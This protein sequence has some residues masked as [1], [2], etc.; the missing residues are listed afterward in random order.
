MIFPILLAS[1]PPPPDGSDSA[2]LDGEVGRELLQRELEKPQYRERTSFLEALLN[3]LFDLLSGANLNPNLPSINWVIVAFLVALL[4]IVITLI[5]T[6]ESWRV[7]SLP[8]K[9]KRADSVVFED[10]R[11]AVQYLAAAKAAVSRE[12]FATA[13][14]E[15]FRHMLKNC[16]GE[17]VLTVN[18]GL[19]A[20]EAS[21]KL[22]RVA[23]E[24][25]A[26]LTWAADQFNAFRFGHHEARPEDYERLRSVNDTLDRQI[27]SHSPQAH[28]AANTVPATP[29]ADSDATPAGSA[30]AAAAP[31]E[32]AP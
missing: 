24:M 6:N 30:A 26:E 29:L 11:T 32:V 4:V 16:E 17:G 10:D 31:A 18:P 22:T 23:K 1:T 27:K 3:K 9:R 15:L 14:L 8:S 13:F 5:L 12:D 7:H 25:A 21:Q 19:T 28:P 20:W 2:P